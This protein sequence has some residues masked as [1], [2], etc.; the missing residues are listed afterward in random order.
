MGTRA[1][2]YVGRGEKAEWL[3]SVAWDGYPA[4]AFKRG[5]QDA[6]GIPIWVTSCKTEETYRAA[7]AKLLGSRDD[8]TRPEQGW[9]WP[10]ETSSTTDYAY[11]FI[12]GRKGNPQ[13]TV[14]TS[15]FGSG[16]YNAARRNTPDKRHNPATFPDMSKAPQREKFGPHSGIV[17]VKARYAM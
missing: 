14:Y 2:F 16:W 15:N 4:R 6:G 12:Q 17:V 5:V 9:P 8:S 13:G 1:D 11:A 3:G 7:V 10:W